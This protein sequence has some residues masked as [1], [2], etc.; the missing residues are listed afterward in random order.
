MIQRKVKRR[1]DPLLD[2]PVNELL[3][4]DRGQME[5]PYDGVAELWWS[6]REVLLEAY[7]AAEAIEAA[8]E[9]VEDEKKF[10]DLKRSPGWCCYEVPQINPTPENIVATEKSPLVKYYYPF[11]HNPQQSLEEAQFYWRVNHG[12]KVRQFG[13][14]VRALRYIQAHRLDDE[15]NDLFKEARGTEVPPYCGHAELW[16]DRAFI[17]EA[18]ATPEGAAALAALIEDE[19]H[20][21]DFSRSSMWLAKEH[22]VIDRI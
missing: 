17:S 9:L 4:G 1:F 5:P 3:P 21:I 11:N 15:L 8:E 16:F 2:D 20:F 6:S 10:V 22:V 19:K 18:F 7:S 12:P 13:P 14:A